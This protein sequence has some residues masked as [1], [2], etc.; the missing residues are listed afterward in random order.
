MRTV[1][2]I[3][4]DDVRGHASEDEHDWLRSKDNVRKWREALVSIKKD[5]ESQFAFKRS[6]LSEF[7]QEC[8]KSGDKKAY[9]EKKS[10]Y[11]KWRAAAIRYKQSVEA[12]LTESKG[13]IRDLNE[14]NGKSDT[15]SRVALALERIASSL[16]YITEILSNKQ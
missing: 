8:H 6:E 10:D 14:E 1:Q 4:N 3:T 5:I 2:E 12:C 15:G 11:A 13:L 9:F 7:Q 16:E